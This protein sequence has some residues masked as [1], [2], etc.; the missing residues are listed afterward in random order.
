MWHNKYLPFQATKFVVVCCTAIDNW[1]TT[2]YFFHLSHG[3]DNSAAHSPPNVGHVWLKWVNSCK[4]LR[5]VAGT[6]EQSVV[7]GVFPQ[8]DP[9][10]EVR[11]LSKGSVAGRSRE[12]CFIV[13][14]TNCDI[15]LGREKFV[16][17]CVLS[18]GNFTAEPDRA[19]GV[20]LEARGAMS[21]QKAEAQPL[22]WGTEQGGRSQSK[23]ASAGL[24]LG[25]CDKL[26]EKPRNN[27]ARLWDESLQSGESYH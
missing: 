11:H 7:L 13:Q 24:F 8:S 16:P 3:K 20:R 9:R 22:C 2:P 12:R 1:Y 23:R 4:V 17:T 6:Y 14:V 10:R 15:A 26:L 25:I 5:T 18:L 27:W 19:A 21:P